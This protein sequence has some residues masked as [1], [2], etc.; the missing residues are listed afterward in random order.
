MVCTFQAI[1]LAVFREQWI[2]LMSCLSTSSKEWQ[3]QLKRMVLQEKPRR[4]VSVGSL[5]LEGA[6][7]LT[8]IPA[9]D[10]TI[11]LASGDEVACDDS[12]DG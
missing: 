4:E 7:T 11:T 9:G 10:K 1:S 8:P 5:S 6:F 12:M 2:A 3:L